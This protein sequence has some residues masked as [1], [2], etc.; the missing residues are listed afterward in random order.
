LARAN[1]RNRDGITINVERR[2]YLALLNRTTLITAHLLL[3]STKLS[4]SLIRSLPA[5]ELFFYAIGNLLEVSEINIVETQAS[6]EFPNS[7]NSGLIA[8]CREAGSGARNE[9]RPVPAS[10]YAEVHDGIWRCH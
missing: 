9:A 8:D 3:E 7:F 2:G 5:L 10:F 1:P 6:R 4:Q